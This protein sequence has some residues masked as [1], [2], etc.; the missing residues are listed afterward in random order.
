MPFDKM[1]S[2]HQLLEAELC[3]EG[4]LP[5]IIHCPDRGLLGKIELLLPLGKI[6]GL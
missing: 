6:I 1:V 3:D 2:R 4:S 5:L